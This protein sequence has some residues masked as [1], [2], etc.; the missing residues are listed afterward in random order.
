MIVQLLN[1]LSIPNSVIGVWLV[2]KVANISGNLWAIPRFGIVG[3]SAVSS[4][5]F[6]LTFVLILLTIVQTKS[7]LVV[8]A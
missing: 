5:T 4:I 3:A 6:T 1:S 2:S 7:R 8:T